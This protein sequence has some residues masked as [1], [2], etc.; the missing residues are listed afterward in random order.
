MASGSL[1]NVLQGSLVDRP[2]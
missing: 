1:P 2:H